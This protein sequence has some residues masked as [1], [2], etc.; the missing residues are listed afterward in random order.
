MIGQVASETGT[1]IGTIRFYEKQG[2]LVKELLDEKLAAIE[3]KI[4]ELR[5]LELSLKRALQK[6]KRE[7]RTAT[8]GH[9]NCCP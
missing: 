5:S 2:L 6:C 3:Q 7:L 4:N 8:L 9:E 1:S